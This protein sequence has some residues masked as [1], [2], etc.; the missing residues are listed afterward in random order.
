MDIGSLSEIFSPNRKKDAKYFLSKLQELEQTTELT[1]LG[2]S[3]GRIFIVDLEDVRPYAD[4]M[5][6]E[7]KTNSGDGLSECYN[8]DAIQ[9]SVE[10]KK[11]ID[12]NNLSQKLVRDDKTCVGDA[13]TINFNQEEVK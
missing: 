3:Q 12:E 8:S 1:I 10:P 11:K 5:Y 2:G 6:K 7:L 4:H 13:C 9:C